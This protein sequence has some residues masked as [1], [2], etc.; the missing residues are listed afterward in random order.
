MIGERVRHCRLTQGMTQVQLANRIPLSQKQ[1]SRIEQGVFVQLPRPTVIRLAEVLGDPISTGEV[2][3][4]LA[5]CGYAPLIRPRLPLPPQL[6]GALQSVAYPLFCF[7]P[8]WNLRATSLLGQALLN[9]TDPT[10]FNLACYAAE[11]APALD[12]FSRLRFLQWQIVSILALPQEDW[13][14]QFQTMV[15]ETARVSW[16]ELVEEVSLLESPPGHWTNPLQLQRRDAG[17]LRFWPTISHLG[18]RPDLHLLVLY[19]QDTRTLNWCRRTN[20]N[21]TEPRML[22]SLSSMFPSNA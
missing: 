18:E 17:I 12:A 15:E 2:N 4:W 20:R 3:Q 10:I 7:D 16:S 22:S 14:T 8:A 11:G 19:P 6:C 1:V 9:K 21:E 5:E 13:V